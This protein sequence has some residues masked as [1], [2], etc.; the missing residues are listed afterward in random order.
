MIKICQKASKPVNKYEININYFKSGSNL[1]KLV[2]KFWKYIFTVGL[3]FYRATNCDVDKSVNRIIWSQHGTK[4][5]E[6][7][8]VTVHMVY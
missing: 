5:I 7:C 4:I 8:N 6:V 1:I 3:L 2:T